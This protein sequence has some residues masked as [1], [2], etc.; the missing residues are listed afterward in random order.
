MNVVRHNRGILK[1]ARIDRLSRGIR[2]SVTRK[3]NFFVLLH[4]VVV[5]GLDEAR[6]PQKCILLSKRIQK[7]SHN[8][9]KTLLLL[10]AHLLL[11]KERIPQGDLGNEKRKKKLGFSL[12]ISV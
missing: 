2:W 7:T 8:N 4:V 3:H 1:R 12:I 11:L 6:A 5:V 9:N 10:H